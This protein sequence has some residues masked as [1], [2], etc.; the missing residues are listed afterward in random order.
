MK[1]AELTL[2]EGFMP[3]RV[4]HSSTEYLS[5]QPIEVFSYY[6]SEENYP[7]IQQYQA[8]R[9]TLFKGS[10]LSTKFTQTLQL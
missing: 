4:I 2:Y 7:Y 5:L 10:L 3:N 8:S 9:A 6:I 1:V